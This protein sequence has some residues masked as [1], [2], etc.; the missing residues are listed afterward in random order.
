MYDAL[1]VFEKGLVRFELNQ[2]VS[3]LN[4][5]DMKLDGLIV[6]GIL[7]KV[8]LSGKGIMLLIIIHLGLPALIYIRFKAVNDRRKL[9][10]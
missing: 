5:L 4:L 7:P 9:E 1:L 8:S 2:K 10:A 3:L 6:N